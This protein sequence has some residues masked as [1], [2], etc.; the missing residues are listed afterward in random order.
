MELAD[1]L[2]HLVRGGIPSGMGRGAASVQARVRQYAPV[3]R[4]RKAAVGAVAFCLV[5]LC[6]GFTVGLSGSATAKAHASTDHRLRAAA[7]TADNPG[8]GTLKQLGAT[9]SL[10]LAPATGTPTAAPATL[11]DQPPLAARENFAFAPYWTLAQSPTFDITGL[12]TLAYFSIDVNGNGTL[13]E[14]GPGWSG[15]QSQDL[16]DLISRAHAASERVVL[17]VTDFSQSS[18]NAVTSSPTAAA[19]L[20]GTLIPLL[21]AKSLDGVNFDFEGEGSGDQTGLTNLVTSVAG[22][23]RAADP[24]WQ[25]T[26]D[27][28]ASSAGDPSGFYNIPALAPAVDAFFVMDYELNLAGIASAASPLTSSMFSSQTTLTQY[29]AAVPA[30][31]VILGTPFFGIDWPT[32][33]GTMEATATGGAADIPD[34]QA[35]SNGPEYWDPV[36]DTAWTSYQAG[37]QWHESYYEGENG[38]YDVSQLVTKDGARG[39]GIW[40]LGMESDGAQMIAALDGISPG[41]P[42]GTGPQSTSASA[43]A[44]AAPAPA[45]GPT[46]GAG[47]SAAAAG[48]APTAGAS[49]TPSASASGSGSGSGSG[50]QAASPSSPSPPPSATTTT[51]A[52]I[53]GVYNGA[54]VS[55]TPVAS[56]SVLGVLGAGTLTGF[57][58]NVPAYSCLNGSTLN[59]YDNVDGKPVAEA[60]AP[61]NCI[62]QDFELP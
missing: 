60:V 1:R 20:S 38:L 6:V 31:K 23:L 61:T 53:T 55:L 26:M 45:A 21:Q 54:R 33:N 46:P 39:V 15:F 35:A 7:R 4:R 32:N 42:P 56:S 27:T 11:A 40:A 34:S 14:S 25:I 2:A 5:M 22:S 28:Y 12:S 3:L 47:G 13:D 9:A 57:Q 41:A 49:P 16:S 50:S 52:S 19:T 18:L 48:P 24:H 58:T 10:A 43:P 59:V 8:N 30:S 44:M 17:T 29:D 51:V 62:A 37:G 36:T